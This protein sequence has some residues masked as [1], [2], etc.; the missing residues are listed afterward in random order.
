MFLAIA[1]EVKE[2]ELIGERPSPLRS[3]IFPALP[4]SLLGFQGQSH[5]DSH[6][7]E[8]PFRLGD[9]ERAEV[10]DARRQHRVGFSLANRFA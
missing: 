7:L 10:K 2:Y 6:V 1:R 9:R 4:G 3:A 5:G 8:T